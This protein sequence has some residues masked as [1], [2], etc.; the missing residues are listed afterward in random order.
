MNRLRDISG[1]IEWEVVFQTFR[2][3]FADFLHGLFDVLRHFHS[4]G[5]RK[6]VDSK[7]GCISSVDTTFR[8]IGR[9]FQ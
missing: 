7:N 6:H 4:V 2:E 9:S 3:T 1:H 8:A 5:S